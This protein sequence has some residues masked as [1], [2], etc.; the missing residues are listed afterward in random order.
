VIRQCR[1]LEI[2]AESTFLAGEAPG[3]VAMAF[4]IVRAADPKLSLLRRGWGGLVMAWDG[5]TLS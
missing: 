1:S 5:E 4:P 2:V 3:S